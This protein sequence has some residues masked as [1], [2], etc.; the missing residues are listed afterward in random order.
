MGMGRKMKGIKNERT[1]NTKIYKL[2][3]TKNL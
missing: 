3:I 1:N 2:I